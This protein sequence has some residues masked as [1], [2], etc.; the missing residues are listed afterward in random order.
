MTGAQTD[1][2]CITE[3]RR[4]TPRRDTEFPARFRVISGETGRVSKEIPG[5]VKNLSESGFC[6]ATNFTIVE[7]LHVLSSSSG[8]TGN[9]LELTIS[10]PGH[11]NLRMSGTACWYD[12]TDKDD[13]YRYNVGIHITEIS[14]ADLTSLK[15]FLKEERKARWKSFGKNWLS[16]FRRKG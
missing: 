11:N 1:N 16:R 10:V 4:E 9:I 5:A 6:L 8:V 13:P 2:H 15:R 14:S 12:L 3:D 7:E